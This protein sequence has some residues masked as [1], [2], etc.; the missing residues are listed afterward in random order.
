MIQLT[1]NDTVL[2]KRQTMRMN[3][4]IV[5]AGVLFSILSCPNLLAQGS[6]AI[7]AANPASAADPNSESRH[8]A[9]IEDRLDNVTAALAQTQQMLE[10]STA[11]I[12]RL[13]AEIDA[14]RAQRATGA[15]TAEVTARSLPAKVDHPIANDSAPPKDL[16]SLSEQVDALQAEIKQHDQIKVETASKYSL[17]VSGLVLFNAFSNAGVVDNIELPMFALPRTPG[18]SHGSVGASMRQTVLGLEGVGPRL[19][20][21]RSSADIIIDSFGD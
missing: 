15:A 6:S 7:S 1:T 10:K 9:D 16:A 5:P 12:Q 3:S 17:R 11:E 4:R 8:I 13:H 20:S 21:A 14:L 2:R 19:W 18:A